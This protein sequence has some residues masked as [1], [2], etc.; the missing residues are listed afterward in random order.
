MDFWLYWLGLWVVLFILELF[1]GSFDFL[2]LGIASFVTALMTAVL[3]IDL[4][5][6]HQS[7]LIF[8]LAA[9]IAI[10]ITRL[11]VT[12]KIQGE[13]GP[14][15]MSADSI[16]GKSFQVQEINKKKVI[17]YEGM[18]WNVANTA[19]VESGQ[20]VEVLELGDNVVTVK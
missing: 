10:M 19:D 20:T 16:I 9:V 8:L 13:D 11:L 18:Y 4:Q 1:V 7:G 15:P 2:A 17:K 5:D 14:S 3:G 6:R 12:P